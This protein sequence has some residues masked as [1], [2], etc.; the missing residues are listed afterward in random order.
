MPDGG[1]VVRKKALGGSQQIALYIKNASG[2]TPVNITDI[3]VYV[4]A[5]QSWISLITVQIPVAA[6]TAFR[7]LVETYPT[8]SHVR[9]TMS[10]DSSDHRIECASYT[11]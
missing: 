11:P 6:D 1:N 9:I 10:N 5:T 4:E 7:Q 3:E 2:V 8:E